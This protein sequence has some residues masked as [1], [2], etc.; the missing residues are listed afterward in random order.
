MNFF[1]RNQTGSGQSGSGHTGSD[2][3]VSH[4]LTLDLSRADK[5]AAMVANSRASRVIEVSD[6]LAGMYIHNWERLSRYWEE[7]DQERVE[8][9]LRT[10]CR[11]SPARWNFWIQKYDK[12]RRESNKRVIS[13]PLLR[14]L[15]KEPIVEAP[16]QPSAELNAV[17]KQA[18]QIAPFHDNSNGKKIPILTSECVLLCIVRNRKSEISRRLA[19]SGL[20]VPQLERDALSSR[21]TQRGSQQD[22]G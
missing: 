10:V 5:F 7:G 14:K 20:N 16:L 13:L 21:R 15:E 2:E 3:P 18:E 12:R 19:G 8:E 22:S 9:L 1:H 4:R 11:I 6:L 17:L